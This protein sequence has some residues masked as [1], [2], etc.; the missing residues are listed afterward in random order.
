M[1]LGALQ[2]A[3]GSSSLCYV[4]TNH[5][6]W[7]HPLASARSWPRSAALHGAGAHGFGQEGAR[8]DETR[9]EAG[10]WRWHWQAGGGPG[11]QGW[12]VRSAT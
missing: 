1:E 9:R 4:A 5:V 10:Y 6:P 7:F 11:E 12:Q 3:P 2:V 8:A